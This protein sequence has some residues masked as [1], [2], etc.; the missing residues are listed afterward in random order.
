MYDKAFNSDAIMLNPN[1]TLAALLTAPM[2]P[3]RIV[4]IGVRPARREPVIAVQAVIAEAGK[5]LASER[6]KTSTDGPRQVTLIQA[7]HLA[8]IASYLGHHSNDPGILRRNIVV[9]GINLLAMKDK[10]FQI[11]SGLLD[12]GIHRQVPSLFADGRK[13]WRGWLQ[14]GARSWRYHCA[15]A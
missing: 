14:R 15:R 6:H 10:C 13:S 11:G 5:G 8:A 1:S 12:A 3:G 9:Q 2:N 4:W 7:E